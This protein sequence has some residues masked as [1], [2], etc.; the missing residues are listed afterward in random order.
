M[1]DITEIEG[2]QV[3]DTVTVIGRDGDQTITWDDWA[4]RLGTI[5]YELVCGIGKRVP[6]IYMKDGNAVDILQY[7]V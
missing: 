7:I 4:D 5:S 2:V 3:G 1:I 6:R